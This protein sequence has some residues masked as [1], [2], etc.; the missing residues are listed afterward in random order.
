MKGFIRFTALLGVMAVSLSAQAEFQR[1][2]RKVHG[3]GPVIAIPS[4]LNAPISI[5][6]G[7]SEGRFTL[8]TELFFNTCGTAP[9]K[10][11]NVTSA[12]IQS[13]IAALQSGKDLEGS[14]LKT[15][16]FLQE[17]GADGSIK[18]KTEFIQQMDLFVNG[19]A[20]P[21]SGEQRRPLNHFEGA[22]ACERALINFS[23]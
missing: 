6:A 21:L 3:S 12:E 15:I 20:R 5:V 18:C 8:T 17:T 4:A 19:C 11:E 16:E 9:V 1:I 22:A 7:N 14:L 2:A 23:L 13:T 10:M